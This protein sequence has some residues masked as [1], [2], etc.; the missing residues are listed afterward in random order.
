MAPDARIAYL[1]LEKTY[2]ENRRKQ[3]ES[4]EGFDWQKQKEE[5]WALEDEIWDLD[6]EIESIKEMQKKG[7]GVFI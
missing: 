3:I 5:I 1:N 2:R 6:D 7:K 4:S